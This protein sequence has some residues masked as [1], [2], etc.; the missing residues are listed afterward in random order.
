MLAAQ[1]KQQD[2][3]GILVLHGVVDIFEAQAVHAAASEALA[4]YKAAVVRLDSANAQRLDLSA[5]QILSALRRDLEA[6]SRH[7]H[8]AGPEAAAARAGLC[9]SDLG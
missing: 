5:L 3:E 9:L 7:L 8:V 2:A 4:D 1:Y 6:A